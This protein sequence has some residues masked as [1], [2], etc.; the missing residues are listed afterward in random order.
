[1]LTRG[2]ASQAS[3]TEGVIGFGTTPPAVQFNVIFVGT[4]EKIGPALSPTL[5]DCE[6]VVELPQASVAVQVLTIL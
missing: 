5:I 1:M 6:A 4:F 2:F 3:D